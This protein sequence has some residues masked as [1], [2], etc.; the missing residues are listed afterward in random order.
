MS[1]QDP[2][3]PR[4]RARTRLARRAN[5]RDPRAEGLKARL[6]SL[7]DQPEHQ[8]H[9]LLGELQQLG[10]AHLRLLA[11]LD[12]ITRISDSFQGQ[13]KDLNESLQRASRTDPLT[14]I[15][16]RR[17][18]MEQLAGEWV[19][20][21][22]EGASLSVL[23]VDLDRFKSVNDSKGHEAGDRVLHAVAQALTGA[24][25]A[26]DVCARWGG[27]EFLVLLPATDHAGA[28]DVG[29]KLRKA[30][31]ALVVPTTQGPVSVTISLGAST[32]GPGDTLDG[33]LRR[34]DEAMYEAKGQGGDRVVG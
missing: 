1:A 34:A 2:G 32:A 5:L 21:L 16:N 15:P 10:E 12:K 33:L 6:A 29:E 13:L 20:T 3:G 22:R 31:A 9:P 26:Y 27:E 7:R 23:M 17:A 18:M 19:R 4:R 24:L 11:R 25:R 14:G 8:G 30:V 28:L